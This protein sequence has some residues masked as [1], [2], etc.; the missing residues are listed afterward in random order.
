MIPF[1]SLESFTR[2]AIRNRSCS[3][4]LYRD[5]YKRQDLDKEEPE[6]EAAEEKKE[7]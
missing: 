4:C 7:D 5:V 3:D 6:K 2:E 1:S